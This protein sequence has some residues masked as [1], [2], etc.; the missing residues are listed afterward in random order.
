MVYLDHE[1]E[2]G[3]KI[4]KKLRHTLSCMAIL[5]LSALLFC[6]S[7]CSLTFEKEAVK[8]TPDDTYETDDET[9]REP[10]HD[11]GHDEKPTVLVA[12][13]LGYDRE[14]AI[15]M[16]EAAGLQAE[17]VHTA[18]AAP[19]DETV[20]QSEPAAG[21]EV[22]EGET[23][24]IYIARSLA[25]TVFRCVERSDESPEYSSL[26]FRSIFFYSNGTFREEERTFLGS[27]TDAAATNIV[28]G[29]IQQLS[30][31]PT[32]EWSV[33]GDTVTLHYTY[34]E[35]E[36]FG[37]PLEETEYMILTGL[38]S[39]HIHGIINDHKDFF[40]SDYF[41]GEIRGTCEFAQFSIPE[42]WTL[43]G[44]SPEEVCVELGV[45]PTPY[46]YK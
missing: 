9:N 18:T 26:Y 17:V 11:N 19:S 6:L 22:R 21:S 35:N 44:F 34:A 10:D 28:W 15:S 36:M 33:D 16:L 14:T 45:D 20:Y 30:Y 8:L 32:G 25:D 1:P 41:T 31:F 43:E 5:L 46:Y 2:R 7:G 29:S 3:L 23:V 40:R 13:V 24:K 42:E 4:M 27:P 37:E 39:N 12:D 38:G